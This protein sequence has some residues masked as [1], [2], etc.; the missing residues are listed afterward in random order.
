MSDNEQKNATPAAPVM[1]REVWNTLD[2]V[3]RYT[4]KNDAAD[5]PAGTNAKINRRIDAALKWLQQQQ[6]E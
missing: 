6:T 3:L 2:S 1:P 4:R 5:D